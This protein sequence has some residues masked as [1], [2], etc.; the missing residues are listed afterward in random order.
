M[1]SK[2]LQKPKLISSFIKDVFPIVKE[3][4]NHWKSMGEKIPDPILSQQALNSIKSKS[5]HCQG[6]AIYSLYTGEV[7][8]DIVRFIV[9]LQTISDYLDNLCDRM[10]VD[11]EKSFFQLHMAIINALDPNSKIENYYLLY[12]HTNDGGYLNSL[13]STCRDYILSLPSYGM[14]YEHVLFLG[15]LYCEMQSI[16]HI[17]VHERNVALEKWA[18]KYHHLYPEITPWEFSAASGSTLGIF[19]L[20]TLAMEKN[21]T[22]ELVNEA[23]D[24]Y[25]PWICGLHILLDYFI[26]QRE[27]ILNNDLNFLSFYKDEKEKK[28]RLYL[29]LSQSFKNITH[30][31]NSY[32]HEMIIQG[33][34]AMYLSD[35]KASLESEKDITYALLKFSGSK[36]RMLYQICRTLR[37]RG[38]ISS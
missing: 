2:L 11:N 13:V 15:R 18:R 14:V 16:K 8:P 23:V 21:L 30:L 34:L 1:S 38:V 33:L 24:A 20:C 27:D 32:F 10:G 36:T 3:N 22:K 35:E 12:P 19:L 29:F 6:G 9:A 31:D 4:L 28:E 5:F 17:K 25:F 26:D 7:N 37:D